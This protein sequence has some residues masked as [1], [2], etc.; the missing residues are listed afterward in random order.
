MPRTPISPPPKYLIAWLLVTKTLATVPFVLARTT[1]SLTHV[2]A[3]R[4]ATINETEPLDDISP[5][6]ARVFS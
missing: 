4:R 5:G 1:H 2:T 6:H 3:F